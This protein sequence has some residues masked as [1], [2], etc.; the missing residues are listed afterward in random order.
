MKP[1][2]VKIKPIG[3]GIMIFLAVYGS[4]VL[5]FKV[6][7][8]LAAHEMIESF[9]YYHLFPLNDS[10]SDNLIVITEEKSRETRPG[11]A[12]MISMLSGWDA[13][14]IAF[15]VLFE[16]PGTRLGDS[17]LT[18]AT[19]SNRHRIIH[20]IQLTDI[21]NL[22]SLRPGY[23]VKPIVGFQPSEESG[24]GGVKLPFD[25]LYNACQYLAH[26]TP[27]NDEA[28]Q[29]NKYFPLTITFNK[30][31]YAALAL[32]S[33]MRLLEIPL[34]SSLTL[35]A[36]HL[37]V[38]KGLEKWEIP[39]DRFQQALINFIPVVSL[40]RK[41]TWTWGEFKTKMANGPMPLSDKIILIGS[42][43]DSDDQRLG[44]HFQKYPNLY[45]YA[46]LITQILHRKNIAEM[47]LESMAVGLAFVFVLGVYLQLANLRKY[48]QKAVYV[49]ICP[50]LLALMF[51]GLL[52]HVRFFIILPLFGIYT[53]FFFMHRYLL[54]TSRVFISYSHND[55]KFVTRLKNELEARGIRIYIDTERLCF[56][57]NLD[58]FIS[59]SVRATDF[60]ISVISQS[61]LLSFWVIME[62]LETLAS[63][64]LRKKTKL[65]AI[66][67]DKSFL[68]PGFLDEIVAKMQENI[69]ALQEERQR[70]L[71]NGV[72]PVHADKQL[73]RLLTLKP[74]IDMVMKRLCEN[75]T[76]DFSN[77]EQ[78]EKNIPLLVKVIK[79]NTRRR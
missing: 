4:T 49:I 38:A 1:L 52:N 25:S 7:V 24:A 58:H 69:Q 59:K 62:A 54:Q 18:T 13:K 32:L 19:R 30:R 60:T 76:A 9:V 50:V 15:D 29:S 22:S 28:L 65:I 70:L 66:Y 72:T 26:I 2:F 27:R 57:E 41:C 39:V 56:G 35:F 46:S 16:L 37:I 51:V 5:L 11:Y 8:L 48:R 21:D 31:Y 3:L 36:D 68:R 40:Q 14:V 75:Y 33:V 55:G 17:L 61:S 23:E 45:V 77:D 64:K 67:I 73:Q 34:D 10:P 63:E 53:A 20:G 44:P 74:N 47:R 78:F 71:Q 6:P 12:E 43:N 79:E 42:I